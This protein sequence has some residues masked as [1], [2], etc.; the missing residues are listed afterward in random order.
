MT[1]PGPWPNAWMASKHLAIALVAGTILCAAGCKRDAD[2]PLARETL[3]PKTASASSGSAA[4]SHGVL[5]RVVLINEA[6][7]NDTIETAALVADNAIVLG[8][9]L[10][11]PKRAAG[12]HKGKLGKRKRARRR[13]ID[14]DWYRLA[15]PAEVGLISRLE[16][17]QGPACGRLEVW[18]AGAGKA[19]LRTRRE[20]G[21][22]PVLDALGREGGDLLVRVSCTSRQPLKDDEAGYR[23]AI[24][25]RPRRL[26][27]EVEPNDAADPLTSLIPMGQGV[28]ATLA[29]RHDADVF[30][31][32]LSAAVPSEALVLGVTGVPGVSLSVRLLDEAGVKMLLERHPPRGQGVLLPNLDVRRTGVRPTL[33]IAALSGVGPDAPYSASIRPLLPQGCPTQDSCPE[34]VP[35]EREPNDSRQDA[36]GIAAGSL[37]TGVIDG[38]GDADWYAIDGEPGQVASVDLQPPEGLALTLSVADGPTPWA[39]LAATFPGQRL[40]FAGWLLDRRRFYV[41][42]GG[43]ETGHDRG[44][45]YMLRV[46]LADRGHFEREAGSAA[47][48]PVEALEATG[49]G[50]WQRQGA[51]L[52]AGDVDR[53]SLDLR[54]RSGP[55]AVGL[56]CVGDGA[57]GLSCRLI[58]PTGKEVLVVAAPAQ[59]GAEGHRTIRLAPAPWTVEVRAE[60]PRMAPGVYRVEVS[61]AAALEAALAL[62]TGLTLT[63]PMAATPTTA[64]P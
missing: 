52:P 2:A 4:P 28:Q 24:T 27:E 51:L 37:I 59:A 13:L 32:D 43:V 12:S 1:S 63:A 29:H 11:A 53:F 39:E 3:F 55:V 54:G 23:L 56:G 20:R 61:D 42:I 58:D 7:D 35:V 33:R 47:A 8:G 31:L 49:M 15:A 50:S 41:R 44:H 30:R 6:G 26:D 40:M 9:F 64:S 18:R 19:L 25:T 16:L 60:P 5:E 57:P 36:M 14:A 38:P 62:P 45:S 34:R 46:R 17:R 10:A 21:Q 22:R 48:G